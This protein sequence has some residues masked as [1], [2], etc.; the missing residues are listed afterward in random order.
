MTWFG[1]LL[2]IYYV[3]NMMSNFYVI[4]VGGVEVT[5]GTALF[6]TLIQALLIVGIFTVGTGL[7]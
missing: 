6:A 3:F 2:V 4:G 1:I 5:P 7:M